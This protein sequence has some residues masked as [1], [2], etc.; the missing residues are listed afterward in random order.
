MELYILDDE[1]KRNEVVESFKSLIWTERYSAYGDFEM[2]IDPSLADQALFSAGTMLG[3]DKSSRVMVVQTTEQTTADD[4]TAALKVNG[5]E[6]TEVLT[7][8][9]NRPDLTSTT[10][11]LV[12]LPAAILRDLFEDI[13]ITNAV[14]TQDNLPVAMGDPTPT[15]I[16]EPGDS[17]TVRVELES[18]YSTLKFIADQYNLGFRIFK[19]GD[20][21]NLYYEV[22][23][24]DDRTSGQTT[25]PSVIFSPQLDNLTDTSDLT[26]YALLRNVA[27]VIAPNGTRVVYA[28]GGDSSTEGFDRRAIFVKADDIEE[29]AGATLDDLLEQRGLEELSKWRVVIAFDGEISQ[30]AF[31]YG[32]DYNLGDLVEK[33]NDQG[34]TAIMRV[35]E[36]IFVSDEAGEKSYPTLSLDLLVETGTW[37]S[38]GVTE[39]PDTDPLEWVDA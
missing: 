1:F 9:P 3:V 27:Y 26:S 12:G 5:K 38:Y 31:T 28:N 15:S 25:F 32:V 21:G 19:D 7:T 39:W 16:P 22:Y 2:V 34:T 8:R 37:L 29:V 6:L 11:D 30:T 13:C 18:L 4:G 35:T 36:Q 33:R 17:V 24:G 20:T 14:N 10:V 23:S